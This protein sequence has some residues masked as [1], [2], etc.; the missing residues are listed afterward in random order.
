M[1]RVKKELNGWTCTTSSTDKD[2]RLV[3]GGLVG[4]RVYYSTETLEG[5]GIDPEC[6]PASVGD[7]E[8]LLAGVEPDMI[9]NRGER[10]E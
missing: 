2:G 5:A 8:A 10:I 9:F 4:R 3:K 1:I 6:D 7:L